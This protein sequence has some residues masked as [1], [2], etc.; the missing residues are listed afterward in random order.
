PLEAVRAE[1]E[2]ATRQ[3]AGSQPRAYGGKF[4]TATPLQEG[5]IGGA[6]QLLLVLWGAVT[7]V[8]LIMCTNLSNMLL[9]R[10][11]GREKELAVRTSVG[12]SHWRLTR[13]LLTENVA[14]GMCGGALGLALAFTLIRSLPAM[15]FTGL[16][17]SH[18]ITVDGWVVM[19]SLALASL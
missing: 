4:L 7:C 15:G 6:R 8:L 17:R 14:L 9:V 10:A 2:S 19:F 11:T 5:V 12:A 1:L 13:Q 16:P 18:E 3:L